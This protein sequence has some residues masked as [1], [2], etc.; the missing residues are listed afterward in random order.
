M[1]TRDRLTLEEVLAAFDEHLRRTRGVCAG[2]RR[3]YARYAG[4]FLQTVFAGGP[5]VPAE[6]RVQHVA[7]LRRRPDVPLP[8]AD[9]GA[10]GV[11]A[12]LVL[13]VPARGRAA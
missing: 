7:R 4:A 1:T 8:A 11:G 9:G 13:P 3:N 2:T 12:A 6:I 5:V 10:G